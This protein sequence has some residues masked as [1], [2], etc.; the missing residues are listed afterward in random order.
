MTLFD[1][2]NLIF[3]QTMVTVILEGHNSR[4]HGGAFLEVVRYN[5]EGRG[6]I[7]NGS[8]EFLVDIILPTA[9]RLCDRYSL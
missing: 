8:L 3:L 6:F 4:T 1:K 9:L 5:P 2:V 7:P